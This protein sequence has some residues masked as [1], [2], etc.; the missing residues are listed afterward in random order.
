MP[1]ITSSGTKEIFSNTSG[2]P[3]NVSALTVYDKKKTRKIYTTSPVTIARI[4]PLGIDFFG[5]FKSPDIET[6]ASNPVTAGKNIPNN[7][8]KGTDVDIVKIDGSVTV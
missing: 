8:I 4:V 3:A 5:S 1:A 6:P 2:S 7:R